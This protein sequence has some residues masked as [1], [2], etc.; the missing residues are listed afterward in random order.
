M[1]DFDGGE[2]GKG[3]DDEKE[4]P[5]RFLQFLEKEERERERETRRRRSVRRTKE[6]EERLQSSAGGEGKE[7]ATHVEVDFGPAAPP[8]EDENNLDIA[9]GIRKP[10]YGGQ[11]L[12]GEGSAMAQFVQ[13]GERIPRRGEVGYSSEQIENFERWDT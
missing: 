9:A 10:G 4:Q 7:G 2:G 5:E 12:P 11:L 13:S 6:E 1:P 3:K 8:P